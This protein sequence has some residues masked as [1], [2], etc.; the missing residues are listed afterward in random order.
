MCDILCMILRPE[1]LNVRLALNEKEA[2]DSDGLNIESE[3]VSVIVKKLTI[4]MYA[5]NI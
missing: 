3:A 5:A 4:M 1:M 2:H